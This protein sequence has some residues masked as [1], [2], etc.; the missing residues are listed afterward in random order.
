M[1]LTHPH[2]DHLEGLLEVLRRYRVLQV[3]YLDTNYDTP[4]QGNSSV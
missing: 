4:R 3:L 2:E 1:V